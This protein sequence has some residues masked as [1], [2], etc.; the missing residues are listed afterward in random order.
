MIFFLFSSAILLLS[1]FLCLIVT[2]ESQKRFLGCGGVVLGSLVGLV[3][4]LLVLKNNF[5]LEWT[6]G[7]L[8][9]GLTLSLGIDG[10]SAFFLLVV[11]LL[12]ALTGVYGFS[13]FKGQ[14]RLVSTLPFFPLLVLSMAL[15]ISARDGFFFLV[16]W[17]VMSLASFFLVTSEHEMKEVRYAG[18]IYLIATHLATAFLMLFFVLLYGKSGSFLFADFLRIPSL[19][20]VLATVLFWFALVGFGT[21]A[22]IFP[23][24]IWLPHAH[25]AAPSP[26]SALMSGVMIK[27][28]IYGLL[29]ALT[30]LGPIP[31]GWGEWLLGFS[32]PCWVFSMP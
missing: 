1:S 6:L 11:F 31:A 24:H 27:T 12:S 23:F 8:L 2:N 17:E 28:G 21:K 26:V 15:V 16:C 7:S 20:P 18:W 4:S 3:P 13:Y 22:G 14:P 29:R 5:V 32:P 9:P 19:S 30:F 25:P 10:L